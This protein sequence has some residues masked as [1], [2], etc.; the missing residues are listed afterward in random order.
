M[1][2]IYLFIYVP[3]AFVIFVVLRGIFRKDWTP[4]PPPRRRRRSSKSGE[5]PQ[6]PWTWWLNDED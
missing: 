2:F 3:A 6:L 1:I 5:W 4:S